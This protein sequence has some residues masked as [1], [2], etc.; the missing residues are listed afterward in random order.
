MRSPA[1]KADKQNLDDKNELVRNWV[2]DLHY[3][4]VGLSGRIDVNRATEEDLMEK[5]P[6]VGE[7]T[8]KKI[9][10]KRRELGGAFETHGEL[11]EAMG[12]SYKGKG[13]TTDGILPF[14]RLG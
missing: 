6:G 11:F 4:K 13:R 10:K 1:W 9:I 5:L 8:A 12:H 3:G 14:V 7:A 2:S